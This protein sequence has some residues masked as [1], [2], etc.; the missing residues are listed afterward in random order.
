MAVLSYFELFSASATLTKWLLRQL[1]IALLLVICVLL[2]DTKLGR[3]KFHCLQRI[4][5]MTFQHPL[6]LFVFATNFLVKYCAL[7]LKIMDLSVTLYD[8]YACI[9]DCSYCV[10]RA[11]IQRLCNLFLTLHDLAIPDVI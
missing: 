10:P 3:I 8:L 9:A 5:L 6:I 11:R 4:S 1:R 2:I 7:D